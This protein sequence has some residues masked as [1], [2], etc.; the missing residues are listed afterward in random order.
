MVT[1]KNKALMILSY[2]Q[3]TFIKNI[4]SPVIPHSFAHQTELL[5]PV[6]CN[7]QFQNINALDKC[8]RYNY[9]KRDYQC[10]AYN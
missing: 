9:L 7:Y 4:H 8:I 1:Y 3:K 2:V 5:C 10:S 6:F